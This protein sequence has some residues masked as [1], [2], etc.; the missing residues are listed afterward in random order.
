M[1]GE[2]YGPTSL[3]THSARVTEAIRVPTRHCWDA[4]S[5]V[6]FLEECCNTTASFALSILMAQLA[7]HRKDQTPLGTL[8]ELH[9]IECK[10][11]LNAQCSA[12]E[13]KTGNFA[14]FRVLLFPFPSYTVA[15]S[16]CCFIRHK[17]CHNANHNA[18]QALHAF[19][20]P[21]SRQCPHSQSEFN[22]IYI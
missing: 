3:P 8:P 15:S 20:A 12:E 21:T 17:L 1:F 7:S 19:T 5:G 10:K 18:L 2:R 13:N 16:W 14:S 4:M 22:P 9:R 11:T 6:E